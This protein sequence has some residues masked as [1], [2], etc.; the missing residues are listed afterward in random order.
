MSHSRRP[1]R[2]AWAASFTIVFLLVA[3]TGGALARAHTSLP[4]HRTTGLAAPLAVLLGLL[5]T[6]AGVLVT[7]LVAYGLARR[8]RRLDREPR[9]VREP[10]HRRRV[11]YTWLALAC[12]T[13][14][15][16]IVAPALA[17]GYTRPAARWEVSLL[18]VPALPAALVL[19]RLL[20]RRHATHPRHAPA[21]NDR[22]LADA[23][24][25]AVTAA[26]TL[27]AGGEVRAAV[28]ACYA[29]MERSLAPTGTGR[30]AADT[31]EELLARA[32]D[33]GA[34]PARPAGQLT[35]LFQQA[36]YSRHPM[37]ERDR[38]AAEQ[39]LTD[40]AATLEVSP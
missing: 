6:A 20:L 33:A 10:A 36:R 28:I 15:V 3:A 25:T 39:A 19:A 21:A 7:G 11:T 5:V 13:A 24:A 12:L 1:D 14:L 16:A 4:A 8:L 34:V 18:A 2:P 30:Q 40:L 37:D 23:L 31:P 29:A 38:R 17:S 27:P 9:P 22:Q 32:V 35:G 26:R